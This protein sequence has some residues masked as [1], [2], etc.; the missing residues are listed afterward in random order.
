M[1]VNKHESLYQP[2]VSSGHCLVSGPGK[3]Q[4]DNALLAHKLLLVF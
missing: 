3:R 1:T 2:K 4:S